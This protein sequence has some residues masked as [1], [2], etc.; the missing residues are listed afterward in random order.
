MTSYLSVAV[1]AAACSVFAQSQQAVI[2]HI[3]PPDG[4]ITPA[5]SV[6]V[7]VVAS[8]P[9]GIASVSAGA[10]ALAFNGSNAWKARVPLAPGD[11]RYAIIATDYAGSV[12]TALVTYCR[13]GSNKFDTTLPVIAHVSPPDGSVIAVSALDMMVNVYD[14]HGA[15]SVTVNGLPAAF[16]SNNTWRCPITLAPGTNRFT[17]IACNA[18]SLSATSQIAYLHRTSQMGGDTIPP[19]I[20]SVWPSDGSRTTNDTLGLRIR[21][22]DNQM[23]VSVTVNDQPAAPLP[24]NIW[25]YTLPLATGDNTALIIAADAAGNASS[26]AVS[27]VRL[28]PPRILTTALPDGYAGQPYSFRLLADEC[29]DPVSWTA[30]AVPIG[31]SVL[32][33]GQIYGTPTATGKFELIITVTDSRGRSITQPL[34]IIIKE[35]S[36]FYSLNMPG[37][38][39]PEVTAGDECTVA[40]PGGSGPSAAALART[41]PGVSLTPGNLLHGSPP[42]G[43]YV[44]SAGAED[45]WHWN[46]V[47]A[48]K[49]SLGVFTVQRWRLTARGSRGSLRLRAS[50]PLPEGLRLSRAL[51]VVVS[52]GGFTFVATNACACSATRY[53]AAFAF[54]G[55]VAA[56]SLSVSASHRL[57]WSL[58]L[59]RVPLLVD[60]IT[61]YT[62]ASGTSRTLYGTV[63]LGPHLAH[64]ALPASPAPDTLR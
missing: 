2:S 56:L 38:A 41:V 3:M 30:L 5:T 1:I 9:A 62:P 54:E 19:A 25:A 53:R 32:D 10:Y 27:Y 26:Q 52:L 17:I 6:T 58:S 28:M 34:P 18:E 20:V 12:C 13:S 22:V 39:L 44:F 51:P 29:D 15:P 11:N 63:L 46:A 45:M 61:R 50:S 55:G 31:L 43:C 16:A 33:N 37:G 4:F 7:A 40:L 14:Q 60:R 21:A 42:E 48:S 23:V 57:A 36:E 8:S 59:S 49:A 35:L 47:P 64:F 24:S